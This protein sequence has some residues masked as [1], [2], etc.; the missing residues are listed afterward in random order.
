MAYEKWITT[1]RTKIQSYKMLE[2]HL[3]SKGN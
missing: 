2:K 3:L 1:N